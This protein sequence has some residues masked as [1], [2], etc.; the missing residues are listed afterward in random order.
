MEIQ[1]ISKNYTFVA[2]KNHKHMYITLNTDNT[3]SSCAEHDVRDH[4]LV[5]L[6]FQFIRGKQHSRLKPGLLRIL[7]LP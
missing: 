5:E 6:F 2:F 3:C 7:L 1:L 4:C